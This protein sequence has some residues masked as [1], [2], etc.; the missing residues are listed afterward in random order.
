[1][2]DRE[3]LEN[4]LMRIEDEAR[5][6]ISASATESAEVSLTFATALIGLRN[7]VNALDDLRAEIRTGTRA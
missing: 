7:S 1:M 6:I 3:A 2:S 5:K 4:A